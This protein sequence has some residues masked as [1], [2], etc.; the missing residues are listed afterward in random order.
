MLYAV[1]FSIPMTIFAVWALSLIGSSQN[2]GKFCVL[3]ALASIFGA[4]VAACIA[5]DDIKGGRG[6][7]PVFFSSVLVFAFACIGAFSLREF[8]RY[9]R[10]T[11]T[12]QK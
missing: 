1:A 11:R 5:L 7:F 8:Y 12:P 2:H 10:R 3:L 4:A 9:R 6:T